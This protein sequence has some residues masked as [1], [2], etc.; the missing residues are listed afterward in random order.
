M[1]MRGIA[2]IYNTL[3]DL[4][5]DN[6]ESIELVTEDIN[7]Y[8]ATLKNLEEKLEAELHKKIVLDEI[9]KAID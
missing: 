7:E 9:F 3:M 5:N 8:R 4:R 1:T 6:K 2:D